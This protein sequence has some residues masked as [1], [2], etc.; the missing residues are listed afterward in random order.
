M[1][2]IKAREQL[3]PWVEYELETDQLDP[4]VLRVRLRPIDP[5]AMADVMHVDGGV[6]VGQA[7][8]EVAVNAVAEWDLTENGKPIPMVE[9]T[10]LATLRPIMAES[11]KGRDTIVR[12]GDVEEHIPTLLAIA[13]FEDGR[14][15][16]LFL[17]N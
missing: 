1:G 4:P 10:K 8:L 2:A 11:V 16:K 9:A 6:R 3:S 14:D 13:I 7:L 5:F 17:K 15:K 12:T